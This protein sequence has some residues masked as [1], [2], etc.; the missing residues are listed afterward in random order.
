MARFQREY[1]GTQPGNPVKAAVVTIRI[2]SLDDSPLRLLLSSDA[3]HLAEQTEVARIES[4]KKW[5][6]LSVST[7]FEPDGG[8]KVYPWK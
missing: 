4:D 7:D 8:A 1:S 6:E 5:R 2:A 3:V